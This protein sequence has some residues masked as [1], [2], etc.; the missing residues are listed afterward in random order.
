VAS[1]FYW[2][3]LET[4][5]LAEECCRT[6]LPRVVRERDLARDWS[7][8]LWAAFSLVLCLIL[9]SFYLPICLMPGCAHGRGVAFEFRS[10]GVSVADAVCV[11]SRDFAGDPGGAVCVQG[12]AGGLPVQD[13]PKPTVALPARCFSAWVSPPILPP[14]GG[15]GLCL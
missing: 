2:V 7:T 12:S 8:V 5:G 9:S 13:C 1:A 10:K 4:M 11:G 3:S 14:V 15:L 6:Y